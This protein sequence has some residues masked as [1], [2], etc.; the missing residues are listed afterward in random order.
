ML[1]PRRYTV[2]Q[3]ALDAYCVNAASA[4]GLANLRAKARYT[5]A[6]A[7]TARW[8]CVASALAYSANTNSTGCVSGTGMC[9][10]CAGTPT[11]DPTFIYGTTAQSMLDRILLNSQLPFYCPGE[12]QLNN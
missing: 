10:D 3:D 7:S 4:L 8:T 2:I 9:E 11:E 12:Q 6:G 5:A 1:P